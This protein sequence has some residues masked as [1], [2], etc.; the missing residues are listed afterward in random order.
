[1]AKTLECIPEE[2]EEG[3]II[4]TDQMTQKDNIININVSYPR[5]LVVE[6]DEESKGYKFCDWLAIILS[7][8]L[9][10]YI[11]FYYLPLLCEK[12]HYNYTLLFTDTMAERTIE[13]IQKNLRTMPAVQFQ[14]WV[15]NIPGVEVWKQ[16]YR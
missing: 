11:A 7:I 5:A 4:E 15:R 10:G 2:L 16:D 9:V 14:A 1:M 12:K 13:T 8:T 3:T 6:E